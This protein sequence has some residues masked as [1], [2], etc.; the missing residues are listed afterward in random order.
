MAPAAM[1]DPVK[2]IACEKASR[3]RWIGQRYVEEDALQDNKNAEGID[4]DAD[5]ADNPVNM[6]ISGPT[7]EEEADWEEEGGV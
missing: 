5:N 4:T 3:I 1:A 6:A 2:I 7:K